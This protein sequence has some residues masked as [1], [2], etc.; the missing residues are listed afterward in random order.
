M[1]AL[2]DPCEHMNRFRQDKMKISTKAFVLAIMIVGGFAGQTMAATEACH[3]SC[4][5]GKRLYKCEC[6]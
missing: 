2:Y 5:P 1:A 3:D 4:P 6:I